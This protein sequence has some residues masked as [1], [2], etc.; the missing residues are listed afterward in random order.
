MNKNDFTVEDSS[1]LVCFQF[2]DHVFT[3]GFESDIE[4]VMER[5]QIYQNNKTNFELIKGFDDEFAHPG[6]ILK[7]MKINKLSFE[8]QREGEV[9]SKPVNCLSGKVIGT[10]VDEYKIFERKMKIIGIILQ[11]QFGYFQYAGNI[12]IVWFL[13]M[14]YRSGVGKVTRFKTY[15]ELV[16]FIAENGLYPKLIF[17]K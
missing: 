7:S 15:S 5:F 1:V 3:S 10:L 13:S 2:L 17:F 16:I 9:F 12:E 8:F 11:D 14:N 4:E 6:N